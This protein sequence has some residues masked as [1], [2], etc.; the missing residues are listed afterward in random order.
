MAVALAL[1]AA[2][3]AA[4]LIL[5]RDDSGGVVVPPNSVALIDPSSNR[6]V[7]S[8]RVGDSPG[9]IDAATGAL[10]VLN[11]NNRTLTKIDPRTREVLDTVGLGTFPPTCPLE[12]AG[13]G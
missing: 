4:I 8:I 1:I 6:I 3:L 7:D 10:W 13:S 9:P 11:R 2:V 5:R 12:R